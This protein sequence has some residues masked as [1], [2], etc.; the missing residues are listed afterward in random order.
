MTCSICCLLATSC[1]PLSSRSESLSGEREKGMERVGVHGVFVCVCVCVCVWERER[2]REKERAEE[3]KITSQK[4]IISC[5]K[6]IHA[7]VPILQGSDSDNY[8]RQDGLNQS[9][10]SKCKIEIPIKRDVHYVQLYIYMHLHTIYMYMHT[11]MTL[12]HPELCT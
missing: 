12:V 10:T 2:D 9:I 8:I 6:C 3:R 5:R 11:C 1:L 4:I 7:T